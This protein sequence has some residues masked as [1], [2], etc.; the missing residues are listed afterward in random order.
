[1]N[2]KKNYQTYKIVKNTLDDII[3]NIENDQKIDFKEKQFKNVESNMSL[4]EN[5]YF[6]GNTPHPRVSFSAMDLHTTM[7]IEGASPKHIHS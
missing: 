1:M 7:T 4:A 5:L 3:T 2:I 6:A